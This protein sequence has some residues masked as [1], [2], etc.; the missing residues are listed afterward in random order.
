MR[1]RSPVGGELH[2]GL[3]AGDQLWDEGEV[4]DLCGGPAELED[5]DEGREIGELGPLRRVGATRQTRREDE[6]EGEE[7]AQRPW[8]QRHPV[9]MSRALQNK[10]LLCIIKVYY[11]Y[12]LLLLYYVFRLKINRFIS[13]A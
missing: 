1:V 10:I 8:T 13:L 2:L 5:H 6:A 4:G 3:V 12:C 7:H 11:C 9:W